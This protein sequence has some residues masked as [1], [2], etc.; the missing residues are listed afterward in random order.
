MSKI[1]IYQG[2]KVEISSSGILRW[3]QRS[4]VFRC[5][6]ST[7]II[8]ILPYSPGLKFNAI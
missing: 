6:Q 1:L 4:C 3:V 2:G 7:T 8:L 5:L